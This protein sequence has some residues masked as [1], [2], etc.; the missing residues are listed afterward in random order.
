M[1]TAVILIA[2]AA[3]ALLGWSAVEPAALRIEARLQS[4][5][6]SALETAGNDWANVV[7]DG[8]TARLTGMPPDGPALAATVARIA[9]L[10]GVRKV[11]DATS[12][13]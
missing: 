11:V 8:R 3:V 2:L 6:A 7:I 13:E 4:A 1:R 5:A 10:P 12:G 9:A